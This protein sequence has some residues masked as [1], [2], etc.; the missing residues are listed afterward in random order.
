MS[1]SMIL[2]GLLKGHEGWVTAI[3][4]PLTE[5]SPD[6]LLSA[7]RDKSV[8]LWTLQPNE[9]N[10]P[11]GLAGQARR[12]LTVRGAARA[13]TARSRRLSRAA[14]C[15]A[16]PPPLTRLLQGHS[17]FIADV[18]ISSDGQVR[19]QPPLA[20][21]LFPRLL[22]PFSPPSSS[23]SASPAAGTAPCACGT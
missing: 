21:T 5:G 3:A 22:A 16:S 23:S 1:D 20:L 15:H 18:V 10:G 8:I 7:S 9:D 11:T 2:K 17:H 13:R 14:S 19:A 12:K 6:I 4:C